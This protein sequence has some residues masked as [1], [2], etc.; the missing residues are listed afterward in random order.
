MFRTL[1]NRLFGKPRP[2]TIRKPSQPT[3]AVEALDE[4][5]VPA[6]LGPIGVP[7]GI[8][9]VNPVNPP[10]GN[11]GVIGV[12]AGVGDDLKNFLPGVHLLQ[13]GTLRIIGTSGDDQVTVRSTAKNTYAVD[14]NGTT[15]TFHAGWHVNPLSHQRYYVAL[16]RIELVGGDGDD[17]FVNNTILPCVAEGDAGND[18]LR[19][20]WGADELGGGDGNDRIDGRFGNDTIH[21]GAGN[22]ALNGAEFGRNDDIRKGGDPGADVIYGGDGDDWI[23]GGSGRDW[24]SGEAGDDTLIGGAGNDTLRGG[25]GRDQFFGGSGFNTYNH[26]DATPSMAPDGYSISDVDQAQSPTCQTLASIAAAVR[27]GHDFSQQISNH[28]NG[29]YTVTL[30]QNGERVDI[31][32]YFDGTWTD[33]DAQPNFA[34]DG[35]MDY[36]VTLL[37][38]ARLQMYGLDGMADNSTATMDAASDANG[39]TLYNSAEAMRQ[40]TGLYT[41]ESKV[42]DISAEYIYA[43]LQRGAAIVAD[44]PKTIPSKSLVANHSYPGNGKAVVKLYNPWGSAVSVSWATFQKNFGWVTVVGPELA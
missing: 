15:Q 5:S 16:D 21:G 11:P 13:D 27:A 38:R 20:G 22:D 14:F 37:Q 40:L 18:T 33:F 44:T 41:T 31:N 9:H 25:S 24:L 26:S 7:S 2:R 43:E 42:S 34:A 12:P 30:F 3:L 6:V 36:W 39:G 32:V 10:V 17:L 28:A 23:S 19:G 8:I 29:W 35:R 4:R 1:T